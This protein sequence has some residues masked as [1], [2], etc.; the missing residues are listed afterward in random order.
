MKRFNSS[1]ATSLLT[2]WLALSGASIMSTPALAETHLIDRVVAVV[3]D[4]IILQSQLQEKMQ[5]QQ[6]NL[7]EDLR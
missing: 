3:D 5:E 4:D 6:K 7:W 2:G 1:V